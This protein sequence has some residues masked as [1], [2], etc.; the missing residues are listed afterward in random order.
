M[1]S[2]VCTPM[3]YVSCIISLHGIL[4]CCNCFNYFHVESFFGTMTHFIFH[5]I[6]HSAC[7]LVKFDLICKCNFM[8]RAYNVWIISD[9]ISIIWN[10]FPFINRSISEYK[11]ISII[12]ITLPPLEISDTEFIVIFPQTLYLG[13]DIFTIWKHFLWPSV[14]SGRP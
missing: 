9:E 1:S 10:N 5:N 12:R 3:K 11:I 7:K 14:I 8:P 6:P 4:G 13:A 2:K